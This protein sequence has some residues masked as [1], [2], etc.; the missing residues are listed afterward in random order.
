MSSKYEESENKEQLRRQLQE[1]EYDI[2]NIQKDDLHEVQEET[3]RTGEQQPSYQEGKD[4]EAPSPDREE[5]KDRESKF[6]K[7]PKTS[8]SQQDEGSL[9]RDANQ[10]RASVSPK[11]RL[12]SQ[13]ADLASDYNSVYSS[14]FK[15]DKTNINEDNMHAAMNADVPEREFPDKDIQLRIRDKDIVFIYEIDDMIKELIS[16]NKKKS[17]GEH[18]EI[19]DVLNRFSKLFR[20]YIR[21][22]VVDIGDLIGGLFLD[23]FWKTLLITIDNILQ[24]VDQR[25]K[26]RIVKLQKQYSKIIDQMNQKLADKDREM[27]AMDKTEFIK[28]LQHKLEMIKEEKITYQKLAQDKLDFIEMLTSN[29]KKYPGFTGAKDLYDTARELIE[30]MHLEKTNRIVTVNKLD[31]VF[32]IGKKL[33]KSLS[34]E[35]QTDFS[36]ITPI[37]V[38]DIVLPNLNDY[39]LMAKYEHPFASTLR[40]LNQESVENE[41]RLTFKPY[42]VNEVFAISETILDRIGKDLLQSSQRYADE[43]ALL[44]KKAKSPKR[45]PRSPKR[46]GKKGAKDGDGLAV[47]LFRVQTHYPP[48]EKIYIQQLCDQNEGS[49]IKVRSK[50]VTFRT[51]ASDLY[52]YCY[53]LKYCPTLYTNEM[54]CIHD[55]VLNVST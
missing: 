19:L 12:G 4:R 54:L 1:Q 33:R 15:G 7:Q 43:Q 17:L 36:T 51:L 44:L 52:Q 47:T 25:C 55:S 13:E 45:R 38:K 5:D 49:L 18:P 14:P 22:R 29:D 21:Y 16:N 40:F 46:R 2:I 42:S 41:K 8:E 28:D 35:T 24:S 23:G 50:E 9:E 53:S 39:Q 26:E 30:A 37:K 20:H 3:G 48:L 34:V 32:Q 11:S 31:D 10:H 6:K 27:R